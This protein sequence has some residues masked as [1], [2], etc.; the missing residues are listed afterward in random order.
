MAVIAAKRK[1]E[2]IPVVLDFSPL[3]H[4]GETLIEASGSVGATVY[5]GRD[6]NPAA[7][8]LGLP[9]YAPTKITQRVQEGV[10]GI[11]YRLSAS[12]ETSAGRQLSI[13]ALLALLPDEL[14]ATGTRATFLYT[15]KPFP[16]YEDFYESFQT[17]F[18]FGDMTLSK[19]LE[20]FSFTDAFAQGLTFGD[21]TLRSI[22]Q[23]AVVAAEHFGQQL[24]LGNLTL[25]SVVVQAAGAD[26]FS[27]DFSIGD[28]ALIKYVLPY[29]AP[30][31]HFQQTLSFGDLSLELV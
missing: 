19:V 6:S 23:E 22:V 30:S 15:S 27:Q 10:I 1:G 14:P 26:H 3:L 7:I 13:S 11:L 12:Y 8:L 17:S 28:L 31:D 4:S 20:E 2:I 5:S 9:L 16:I 24:T 25:S 21:I 18:A 29:D